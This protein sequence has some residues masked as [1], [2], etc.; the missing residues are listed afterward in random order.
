MRIDLQRIIFHY[1]TAYER[2]SG[3]RMPA[4]TA[5]CIIRALLF[6][7]KS[8]PREKLRPFPLNQRRTRIKAVNRRAPAGHFV[9]PRLACRLNAATQ[10]T[11][12]IFV[13]AQIVL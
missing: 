8:I 4:F 2:E 13:A 5:A 7:N 9:R 10:Q 6:A 12:I 1:G 11:A 3:R